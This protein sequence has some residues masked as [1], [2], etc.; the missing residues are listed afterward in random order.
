VTKKG[1][2]SRVRKNVGRDRQNEGAGQGGAEKGLGS[3]VVGCTGVEGDE[4]GEWRVVVEAETGT[5]DAVK[6]NTLVRDEPAGTHAEVEVEVGVGVEAG[7][8]TGDDELSCG[9][10]ALFLYQV[11]V[12][13]GG[14]VQKEE[15]GRI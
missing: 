13:C 7:A 11:M 8:E 6:S 2:S 3:L 12:L 10:I 1:M 14:G 9:V 5:R 15:E 4:G